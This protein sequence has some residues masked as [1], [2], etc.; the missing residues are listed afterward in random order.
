MGRSDGSSVEQYDSNTG[1]YSTPYYDKSKEDFMSPYEDSKQAALLSSSDINKASLD[2]GYSLPYPERNARQQFMDSLPEGG[3]YAAKPQYDP[4]DQSESSLD[5]ETYD[6]DQSYRMYQDGMEFKTEDGLRE[7]STEIEWKDA[8]EMPVDQQKGPKL[9]P[10]ATSYN[11]Q[12]VKTSYRN[13]NLDKSQASKGKAT[14]SEPRGQSEIPVSQS[15]EREQHEGNPFSQSG[16]S[17][18]QGN[19]QSETGQY[20]IAEGEED[21]SDINPRSDIQGKSLEPS[22]YTYESASQ[23]HSDFFP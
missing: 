19:D 7:D 4:T 13:P 1:G 9:Q 14:Q 21:V 10:E 20:H 16:G 12:S 2:S 23:T 8:L 17:V 6:F 22:G 11:R 18:H 5:D 3:F 15:E